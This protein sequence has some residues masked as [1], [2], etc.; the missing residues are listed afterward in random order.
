MKKTFTINISGQIFHINEDAYEK[1]NI[2]LEAIGSYF[3]D[4][5]SRAEIMGDIEARI[6]EMFKAKI[7]EHNQVITMEDVNLVIAVMGKPEDFVDAGQPY[8]PPPMDRADKTKRLFRDPDDRILGGVCS[9]ISA[10]FG[11][12]DPIWIRLAFVLMFFA[13]G[14]GP[15]IYIILWIVMPPAKTAAEK[16]E[17]KGEAVNVSNIGKAVNEEAEALKKKI[18][19]FA[20]NSKKI[21]TRDISEKARKV[22][23]WLAKFI[24]EVVELFII[25]F[26]KILGFILLLIAVIFLVILI[27]FLIG[28][29]FIFINEEHFLGSFH[30]FA[31]FFFTSESQMQFAQ[32]GLF[33]LIGIPILG[34]FIGGVKLLLGIRKKY[35]ATGSIMSIFWL[36]GLIICG[37]VAFEISREFRAKSLYN[38]SII[39]EQPQNQLL[40]VGLQDDAQ[41]A[42][43]VGGRRRGFKFKAD[44][45]QLLI[46]YPQ[47]DVK[48][49]DTDSFQIEFKN[50]SFGYD[51]KESFNRSRRI[52]FNYTQED[53]LILM[54]T[55]FRIDKEDK[56]RGQKIMVTIKVPVGKSI[57]F[58]P[59]IKNALHN[60]ENLDAYPDKKMAG[61]RWKMTR[62]GL[63]LI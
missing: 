60:V 9:G 46:A 15:I 5:E 41:N 12:D 63:M 3:G 36:A 23:D 21:D 19:E 62:E 58:A 59:S 48:Q 17:M 57:E 53:S 42:L 33:L 31:L 26:G 55:F 22:G 2:Y 49:S 24:L 7:T 56:Y 54:D 50:R 38:Y 47:I 45:R 30:E 8:T 29:H 44:A 13:L 52:G 20:E 35:R 25:A 18:N 32:V 37:Y 34:L 43:H 28:H 61:K 51:Y 16:L 10:Y 39:P 14:T 4:T 40:I 1:L 27:G 11:I 6:A